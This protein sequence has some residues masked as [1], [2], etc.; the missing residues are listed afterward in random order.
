MT[1]AGKSRDKIPD[2]KVTVVLH[3][4]GVLMFSV[5]RTVC[6]KVNHKTLYLNPP[7]LPCYATIK[8]KGLGCYIYMDNMV[9]Q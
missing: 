7:K 9:V 8:V 3:R 1:I 5:S 2:L 4:F 6:L